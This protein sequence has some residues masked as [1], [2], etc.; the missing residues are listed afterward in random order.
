VHT[1]LDISHIIRLDDPLVPSMEGCFGGRRAVRKPRSRIDNAFWWYAID[2]LQPRKGR[3]EVGSRRSGRP[4]NG[5]G[6]NHN[7]RRRRRRRRR[8][9]G[10]EREMKKWYRNS[11][12]TAQGTL[13]ATIRRKN[14]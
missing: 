13:C 4:W 14:C 2:L 9:K 5:N 12:P 3:D 7:R 1:A 11:F 8:R 10:G 6:P